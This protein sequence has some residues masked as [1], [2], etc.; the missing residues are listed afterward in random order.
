H[1]TNRAARL[2][3]I[4]RAVAAV[5]GRDDGKWINAQFVE[6][7]ADL[8][9]GVVSASSCAN[10]IKGLKKAGYLDSD[11]GRG[12]AIATK[13]RALSHLDDLDDFQVTA[14]LYGVIPDCFIET[15][16]ETIRDS[17]SDFV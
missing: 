4:A 8:D 17:Y 1:A 16:L 9:A 5:K 7:A 2:L 14:K 10:S 11:E 6:L 12:F 13:A 3:T 15:E